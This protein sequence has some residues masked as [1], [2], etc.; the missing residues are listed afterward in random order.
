MA[1]TKKE[2]I[3]RVEKLSEANRNQKTLISMLYTDID[4]DNDFVIPRALV[5]LQHGNAD[6]A[7][8]LA[9]WSSRDLDLRTKEAT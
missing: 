2:Q 5:E 7:T 9:T 6:M 4:R 1:M 8:Q 3:E